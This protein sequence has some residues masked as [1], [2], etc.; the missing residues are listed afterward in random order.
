M[1]KCLVFVSLLLNTCFFSFSQGNMGVALTPGSIQ[2]TVF[3]SL[4]RKPLEFASLELLQKA[5]GNPMEQFGKDFFTP[6]II[7]RLQTD[8]LF[9]DSLKQVMIKVNENSKPKLITGTITNSRGKFYFTDVPLGSFIIRVSSLGFNEQIIENI[10]ITYNS[11]S[12]YLD[13]VSLSLNQIALKEVTIVEQAPLY[14][15]KVD[16]VIY[17][18]EK[19]AASESGNGADVLRKVPM[20]TVDHDGNVQLRGNSNIKVL[21]NGKPSALFNNN[22]KEALRMIPANEIKKVEVITS[23]TA[24]YD[25]EGTAGIINIITKKKDVEGLYASINLSLDSNNPSS[26]FSYNQKK[27]RLSAF[28]N[29]GLSGNIPRGTTNEIYREDFIGLDKRVLEQLGEVSYAYKGYFGTAGLEYEFNELSSLNSSLTLNRFNT[30]FN[31]DA[32]IT[33]SDPSISLFQDYSRVSDGNFEHGNLDWSTDFMRK[34]KKEGQELMIAFQLSHQI[35]NQHYNYLQSGSDSISNFDE[36]SD[37]DGDN[38]EYTLQLDY[39]HPFNEKLKMEIGG[40]SIVRQLKSVYGLQQFNYISEDYFVNDGFSDVFNYSQEVG[41]GYL[42]F[43]STWFKKFEMVTGI[44]YEHTA[45]SGEYDSDRPKFNPEYENWVPNFILSRKLKNMSSLKFTFSNRIQRPSMFYLNPYTDNQ[46]RLNIKKGNPFLKPENTYSYEF[47]YSTFIKTLMINASVFYKNTD[48]MIS[49][50]TSLDSTGIGITEYGNIGFNKSIG[51]NIF[52]NYRIGEKYSMNAGFNIYQ[53][54]LEYGAISNSGLTYNGN[55]GFFGSFKNG[56][57][58][59]FYTFF[60]SA[61]LALQGESAGF[62]FSMFGVSKSIFKDKG[63]IGISIR[64]PFYGKFTFDNTTNGENF[65]QY[66]KYVVPFRSFGLTFT[67]SIGKM[68]FISQ[69]KRKNRGVDNDDLKAGESGQGGAGGA[70]GAGGVGN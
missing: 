14:E 51:M 70:G 65:Y 1:K 46:D 28:A 56:I 63:S 8:T 39:T 40:K 64:N 42:S 11:T 20:V 7:Q 25:A 18:A 48:G 26:N 29:L 35:T 9:A 19:D 67:Y 60:N 69:A 31:N 36:Q 62:I 22:L 3:D 50:I 43:N 38:Y 54:E 37:N 30:I 17:N 59:N 2:G 27:G 53:Q 34:F 12:T 15:T 47:G 58:I 45:I 41:A 5:G 6:Q 16:K 49:A 44:R 24:K 21:I 61:R 57:K 55:I 10:E 32:D 52:M 68:D 33:Y 66:T 4:S 13:P 23:P